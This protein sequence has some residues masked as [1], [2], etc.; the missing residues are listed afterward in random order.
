MIRFTILAILLSFPIYAA[1]SQPEKIDPPG[2]KHYRA[3]IRHIERG[4]IG[5]ETGY[6]TFETFFASDPTAW[7]MTPFLDIRG[8]LFDNGKWAANGGF[9]LRAVW[10]DRVYG[11][12]TYYDYRNG[13]RFHAN[14]IGVGLETLG[15]RL[16]F[17]LNGY[18]P[19]GTKTSA[20]YGF[21]FGTFSGHS[22]LISQNIQS[23]LKGANAELGFHFGTS[24]RFDF[25]A[26]AGP[27]YFIGEATAATWGGKARISGTYKELISLEFSDSY[28]RTFHN[29]FQGQISLSFSFGP[30]SKGKE[31]GS[32][33]K[34]ANRLTD[35]MVQSIDRQEII[36]I[37]QAKKQS[38]AINPATGQPYFFVF[39]DNTSSSE[40][41]YESPYPSLVEAQSNSSPYDIIYVFPG[42]G[43]TA[44]MDN[45]IVL[46]ANQKLWGSGLSHSL[47]T[48]Q[49]TLSIPALSTTLPTMT[50][51][52][53]DTDGNAIT[54]SSY[55][56]ISGIVIHSAMND[57][58]Y[59]IDVQDLEVSF[60][61]FEN[62]NTFPIE[63]TFSNHSS[64]SVT[65]NQFLNN[66]NG[67]SL[68]LNGTSI[69]SCLANRFEGQTSVSNVPLEISAHHN[70]FT[71]QIENNL[72]SDNTTG[73]VRF[74]LDEVIDGEILLVNNVITENGTGSQA[75]L[76]SSFAVL[77][78]GTTDHCSIALQDNLFSGNASNALY[79]HT[80]GQ[81]AALEVTASANTFS[82]N[83]GSAIV[84]ATP[85]DALTLLVADNQINS[86]NDNGIAVISSSASTSGTITIE[87]N[88]ITQIGNASNGIAI[89][90]D[91]SSLHL[92]IVGNEIDGCEGT[93]IIS[94]APT[95]IDSLQLTVSG[96]AIGHCQNL[97]SNG[98][99]G[100]DLEQYRTFIGLISDNTLAE[101]IGTPVFIGSTLPAPTVCLTVT[102]NTNSGDYLLTNPGDGLFRLSP[103]NVDGANGGTMNTSGTI[104]LVQSCPDAVSCTP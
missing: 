23:A 16:D 41:T 104:E 74:S 61:T 25:Y 12:N 99:S 49:T 59:G 70:T 66:A 19:F 82:N 91:F 69:L 60:C 44:G 15:E 38:P 50:N 42:D 36:V 101:N 72:F 56:S 14:Q 35:R 57:A 33:R 96:N 76:G 97:S 54:L 93:G 2:K 80:S 88:I 98:S 5:Y 95:G 65:N 78:N 37:N 102:G 89:N 32:A 1:S 29:Q 100:L 20:P 40:G 51:T 7:S 83:G 86:C 46:K 87:K 31:L 4:G 52:D 79:L 85:V 21:V 64:I 26:A 71:A 53:V 8:H 92:T 43:T 81:F 68:T 62:T 28:D 67:V 30:K 73:S 13:G 11:I 75:S 9:G 24:E 18:L 63:V 77:L 39:V 103:C 58:I 6:T 27:Y 90:Q 48:S 45:G 55:N 47:Q 34:K 22:L 10:Q 3:T 17:R 94:Y 84:L